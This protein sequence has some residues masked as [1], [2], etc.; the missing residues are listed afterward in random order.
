MEFKKHRHLPCEVAQQVK[1]LVAKPDVDFQHQDPPG[2]RGRTYPCLLSLTSTLAHT[3]WNAF[4]CS[5]RDMVHRQI[6]G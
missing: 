2:N 3:L 4:A 6:D 5:H 1:M